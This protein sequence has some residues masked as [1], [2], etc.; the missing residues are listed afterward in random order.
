MQGDWLG[1]S[2]VKW[3]ERME[4]RMV[5]VEVVIQI[6]TDKL[7]SFMYNVCYCACACAWAYYAVIHRPYVVYLRCFA[8][9]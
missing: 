1:R 4:E 9:I 8:A 2:D 3:K 6:S 5:F 7:L